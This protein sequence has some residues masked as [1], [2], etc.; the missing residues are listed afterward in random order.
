LVRVLPSHGR[1][2]QFEPA[3]AHNICIHV[4]KFKSKS[5]TVCSKKYFHLSENTVR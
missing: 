3:I 1:G 4:L 2:R 5:E